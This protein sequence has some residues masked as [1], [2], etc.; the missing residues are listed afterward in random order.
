MTKE[1]IAELR[2]MTVDCHRMLG[3]DSAKIRR[4]LDEREVLLAALRG[5]IE[6]ANSPA[7]RAVDMSA[8]VHG[9][10]YRPEDVA[11]WDVARAA[12]AKAEAE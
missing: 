6:F 10:K 2:Q 12:I 9:V 1:Q 3:T 7:A 8:W 4:V 5:L 11:A